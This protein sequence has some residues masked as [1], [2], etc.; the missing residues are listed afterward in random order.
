MAD[1]RSVMRIADR[2]MGIRWEAAVVAHAHELRGIQIGDNTEKA[3]L[4]RL[5][6][7]TRTGSLAPG[8]RRG[9]DPWAKAHGLQ[10]FGN[11]DG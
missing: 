9:R 10:R 11:R 6:R 5:E 3:A 7:I 2:V 4:P 8:G 1:P